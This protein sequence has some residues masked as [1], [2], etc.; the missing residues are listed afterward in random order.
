MYP[1]GKFSP[2]YVLGTVRDVTKIKR[3][4]ERL[5]TKRANLA[6]IA[7]HLAQTTNATGLSEIV[8]ILKDTIHKRIN[9]LM[10][11]VFISQE[12]QIA[13]GVPMR[14]DPVQAFFFQDICN[15]IGYKAIE[16]GQRQECS[17][18]DYPNRLGFASE[19]LV[20]R[21]VFDFIHSEDRSHA[22]G[23]FS[24]LPNIGVFR[25]F[26]SRFLCKNGEIGYLENNLKYMAESGKTIAIA[27]D[28]AG[29]KEMENR[30]KY[31]YK[32]G[33]LF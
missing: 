20:G 11:S 15:F 12:E 13:R 4:E 5:E 7:E 18:G 27:R 6:T 21:S 14:I 8:T 26:R 2:P 16:L 10:V 29:R 31:Y 23:V 17:V 1:G 25:G 3:Q 9:A 19:D 28:L 33:R 24:N 32:A 22:R 30:R